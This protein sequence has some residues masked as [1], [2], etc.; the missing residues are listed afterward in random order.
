MTR[1]KQ[2][3]I[4]TLYTQYKSM[5]PPWFMKL[6][7]I[8]L[9][10]SYCRWMRTMAHWK[11]SIMLM[12]KLYKARRKKCPAIYVNNDFSQSAPV[13]RCMWGCCGPCPS[14]GETGRSRTPC[15]PGWSWP[16][17]C[18]PRG[19]GAQSFSRTGSAS[20]HRS[21][22]TCQPAAAHWTDPHFPEREKGRNFRSHSTQS[23]S[24]LFMCQQGPKLTFSPPGQMAK[25]WHVNS[26][27]HTQ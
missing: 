12:Y 18:V 13:K 24:I 3:E 1:A 20:P 26:Q 14:S 8:Q 5:L 19:P 27:T 9:Y 2:Y 4:T 7:H 10:I 17:H 22:S 25:R 23:N 11:Y 16:V 21:L 6:Y 15:T